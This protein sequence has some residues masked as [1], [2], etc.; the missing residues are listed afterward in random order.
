MVN[1]KSIMSNFKYAVSAIVGVLLLFLVGCGSVSDTQPQYVPLGVN[2]PVRQLKDMLK[3]NKVK[4]NEC[5]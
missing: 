5:I 3:C 1:L 4:K 2:R